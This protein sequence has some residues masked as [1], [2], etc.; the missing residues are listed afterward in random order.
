[1][2]FDRFLKQYPWVLTASLVGVG[3]VFTARSLSAALAMS[4]TNT[5]P[6]QAASLS[7][8]SLKSTETPASVH[9]TSGQAVLDRNPFDSVT[10]PIRELPPSEGVLDDSD[11][12]S[13]PR[14]E[15]MR[16]VSSVH[17][18]DPAWSLAV[19]G[20]GD[21]K[22]TIGHRGTELF[23]KTIHYISWDRVWLRSGSSLCQVVMFGAQDA[24]RAA[25][26]APVVSVAPGAGGLDPAISGGI[27]KLSGTEYEVARSAVDKILENQADLMKEA[28]IVPETVDGKV[29]GVKLFG[30]RP[31]KILSSIGLQNGDRLD[32]INGFDIGSPEKALE[33]YARLRTADKI[34][35]K[36]N[37]GGQAVTMDYSVK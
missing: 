27:K 1:M 28:R 34:Q 33:A 26:P 6:V 9:A 2:P 16:L 32:S 37:R 25:A 22:P 15:G 35:V 8:T 4:W 11:P 5:S 10:G 36:V 14:C 7:G 12:M 21:A 3:A 24:P 20:Q 13:A 23:G 29:V 18:P 31:G 19:L 17:S 30:I